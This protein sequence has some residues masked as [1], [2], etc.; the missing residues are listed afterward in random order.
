MS[1]NPYMPELA[2][3]LEV[4]E[5]AGGPR[6]IRT[7]KVKFKDEGAWEKFHNRPG[8]LAM[9][10]VFG[11][12]ESMISITSAPVQRDFLEFAVM[13]V[14]KVTSAI[15]ELEAGDVI[16]IRGP[17]GNGFPM[18]E[19]KGKDLYFIGAGIGQA[20]IRSV[21]NYVLHPDNRKDY[22]KVTLIYGARTPEDLSFKDE[23]FD[24]EKRED[25]DVFL[26]IDWKFGKHGMLDEDAAEGWPRINM[27]APAETTPAAGQ[28]RFTCFVPQL[29]E[30]VKPNPGNAVA[31]T[32]GPPIAI[33][34]IT[35]NLEKLG[36]KGEQIL[37]TL[38]NRMKCGIGKCGRCNIG[39]IFVCKDGPVFNYA[40]IK[41]MAQE[42]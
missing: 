5:E 21:Y 10:S 1:D 20:P 8:Q 31:L 3:V 22:G 26:C 4:R 12:G 16:G 23:L 13:R 29:V 30:V 2:E 25:P 17:Y 40:K 6:A 38:E 18:D 19:L 27:S 34:F 35:Q 28:T 32:C 15:H 39:E 41:S 24:Y 42:F 37:T 7:L 33:K 14:G 36:F 11:K 9:L